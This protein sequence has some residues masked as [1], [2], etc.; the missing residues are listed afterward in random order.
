MACELSVL[1]LLPV[2]CATT[3]R[4]CSRGHH[5]HADRAHEAPPHACDTC[6][7]TPF[8]W[9]L[10][11]S[12]WSAYQLVRLDGSAYPTA[13]LRLVRLDRSAYP[14]VRLDRPAYPLVRFDR[15]AYYRLVRVDR[16]AYP[17]VRLPTGPLRPVRLSSGPLRPVR[18]STGPLRPARF[19]WC[20]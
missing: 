14:L 17:M 3:S 1:C 6:M 18:L 7:Q 2:D 10:I 5:P 15:T 9:A 20:A 16:S 4:P 12:H 19:D 8:F 13:P 11:R